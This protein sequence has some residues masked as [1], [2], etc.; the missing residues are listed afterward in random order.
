ML[1]DSVFALWQLAF[2]IDES[3]LRIRCADK[4]AI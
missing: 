2:N 3:E 1:P 4:E